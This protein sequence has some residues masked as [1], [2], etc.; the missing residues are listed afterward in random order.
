MRTTHRAALAAVTTL[1]LALTTAC[2]PSNEEP[3]DPTGQNSA[4]QSGTEGT[5]A[6]A[7]PVELRDGWAKA[8]DQTM[9]GVF[10]TLH[11]SGST[12][13]HLVQASNDL[14]GMTQLHESV[15]DA[16]GGMS[17]KEKE[18]GFVIP[19]GGDLV[20][21]PGGDHLMLMDLSAPI[22]TGRQIHLVLTYADG[23]FSQV[24][25]SAR[26]FA[27]AD[28]KYGAG[29]TTPAAGDHAGHGDHADGGEHGGHAGH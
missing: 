24:T 21:Q 25:V 11:N 2:S 26:S 13:A 6:A 3:A 9:T 14:G 16:G 4:G 1:A 15:P 7:S 22:T 10:G 29:S 28:E 17:M 23:S 18:G 8:T 19:A 27:G 20:L 5:N 12:D